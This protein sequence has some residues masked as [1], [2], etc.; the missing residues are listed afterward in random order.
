MALLSVQSP[1]G[2]C[3]VVLE[4]TANAGIVQASGESS[5]VRL[6]KGLTLC[7]QG[8]AAVSK[9]KSPLSGSLPVYKRLVLGG[10]L[11]I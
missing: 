6:F 4:G 3:E 2:V 10:V 1:H 7:S 11:K 5:K 8:L 9:P